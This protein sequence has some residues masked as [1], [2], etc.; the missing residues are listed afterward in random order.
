MDLN[1]A[2]LLLNYLK[3]YILNLR[4]RFDQFEENLQLKCR[5]SYQGQRQQKRKKKQFDEGSGEDISFS[6]KETSEYQFFAYD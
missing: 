5:K 1:E 3:S 6:E 2:V 4:D